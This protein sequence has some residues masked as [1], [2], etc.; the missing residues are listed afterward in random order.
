M[1]PIEFENHQ[2]FVKLEQLH[3]RIFEQEVRELINIDNINFFETAENYLLDRLRLTIPIIVQESELTII[4]QEI[5]GALGQLNAFIGNQN[6][7]HLTNA[8]NNLYTA[9]SRVRNLPLPFSQNDFNFSKNISNFERIVQDKYKELESENKNLKVNIE[10]LKAEIGTNNSELLRVSSILTQKEAE[11][12]NLNSTFQTDFTNIKSTANQNFESDIKIFRTEFE[13]LKQTL[14]S[15]FVKIEES[16]RNDTGITIQELSIKLTEAKKIVGVIGDVSVTGN[17]QQVANN[18]K[19]TADIFR[20][21]AI[22]LMVSLSALLIFS[23]WDISSKGF[24]WTK[25]LV[26]IIAAAALSYP[27]TYAARESSKHRRLEIINR[28]AEL[29]LAAINPFIELL[30]E[31]KKQ[32][33]KEKLV[34]KYFGNH[35]QSNEGIDNSKEEEVSASTL[36]R[37]LKAILPFIKK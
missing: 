19:K 31:N 20:I 8:S 21:V 35:S 22:S 25:S 15:E 26:R 18:N 9:I 30:P 27:A 23:I 2:I 33:I 24:D 12:Q 10:S 6:I 29:E 32:E 7:G 17:Y 3:S 36:E 37:I 14:N 5:E 1:T 16:I 13:A 4:S 11:I 34:E 28:T